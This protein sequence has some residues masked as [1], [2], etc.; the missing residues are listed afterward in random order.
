MTM[1]NCLYESLGDLPRSNAERNRAL[2]NVALVQ[3]GEENGLTDDELEILNECIITSESALDKLI[4]ENIRGV[5]HA[6]RRFEFE[7]ADEE[8]PDLVSMVL[9]RV[10]KYAIRFNPNKG[11]FYGF[12]KLITRGRLR[13]LLERKKVRWEY[14][15]KQTYID[16]E[17]NL[18]E[19]I[20]VENGAE[21][22]PL[23]ALI[24]KERQRYL[25]EA[26]ERL[27][28]EYP[29]NYDAIIQSIY[30][31]LTF[32]EIGKITGN[33]KQTINLRYHRGIELLRG[34]MKTNELQEA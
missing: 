15:F 22:N 27:C 21:V 10:I 4:A 13:E 23:N 9:I 34:F 30:N 3:N 32:E 11:S 18:L 24:A 8:L 17:S 7:I 19:R 20:A 33:P 14:G 12:T 2:I 26:L 28:N 16:D 1:M 6:V 29:N 5:I 31:G 25:Q